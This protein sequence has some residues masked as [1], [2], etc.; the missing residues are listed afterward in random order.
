MRKQKLYTRSSLW[1]GP[2]TLGVIIGFFLGTVGVSSVRQLFSSR[3][4]ALEEQVKTDSPPAAEQTVATETPDPVVPEIKRETYIVQTGD[5]LSK[6][7]G[8]FETTT[9]MILLLN[10]LDD[11]N[12]IFVGQ[13]LVVRD[14]LPPLMYVSVENN[15]MS[16]MR[17][18]LNGDGEE[19]LMTAKVFSSSPSVA[20]SSDREHIL[21]TEST[22]SGGNGAKTVISAADGT[23]RTIIIDSDLDLPSELH[24]TW[25]FDAS[26]I[27]YTFGSNLW[28]YERS[29]GKRTIVTSAL[30]ELSSGASYAWHPSSDRLIFVSTTGQLT[31]YDLTTGEY[32]SAASLGDYV[33]VEIYWP[34]ANYAYFLT[35]ITDGSVSKREIVRVHL[36]GDQE[37]QQL[38]DNNLTETGLGFSSSSFDF[39]FSVGQMSDS[40]RAADQGIWQYHADTGRIVQMYSLPS[41]SCA[42]LMINSETAIAYFIETQGTTRSLISIDLNDQSLSTLKKGRDLYFFANSAL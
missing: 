2:L 30:S 20:L 19:P 29:G 15:S 34:L 10:R 35:D 32:G 27:A 38:T 36:T 42:P 24:Q 5:S 18:R 22:L 33:P 25:S 28:T 23:D 21:Y 26:Y 39:I 13:E 41:G 12:K 6:I 11:A 14:V 31:T 8:K 17:T 37:L 3:A 1:K 16:L 9:A 7:A 40:A 4:G